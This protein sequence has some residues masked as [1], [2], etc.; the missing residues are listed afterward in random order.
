MKKIAILL[1]ALCIM[2]LVASPVSAE[3]YIEQERS[4]IIQP[5][6]QDRLINIPIFFITQNQNSRLTEQQKDEI[7][8]VVSRYCEGEPIALAY[9]ASYT[10]DSLNEEEKK[11]ILNSSIYAPTFQRVKEMLNEGVEVKYVNL[12]GVNPFKLE[13]G[14]ASNVG[15]VTY[16]EQNY[17][18]LGTYS[19]YKFLYVESSTGIE[20]S[21]VTPG[22]ISSSLKWNEI[23]KKTIQVAC[24]HYIKNVFYKTAQAAAHGLSTLFSVYETPLAI[25]YSSSKGYVKVSMSGDIYIRTILIRDDL[26][27]VSGYAYYNWGTTERL[28]LTVVVKAKYPYLRNASGTNEY[29]VRAYNY[30]RRYSY[31]PGYYGNSTLYKSIINLYNNTAG[32]FTHDESIQANRLIASLL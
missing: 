5:E 27:R 28:G 7:S 3:N 25:T 9:N 10:I 26:D 17:P 12:Y 2:G 30:P 13:T 23:A 11:T 32:Y 22:N 21:E 15:D 24:D 31:T 18:Y 19:G 20:T 4:S 16:W 29:V 1:S 14:R 8:G 6:E